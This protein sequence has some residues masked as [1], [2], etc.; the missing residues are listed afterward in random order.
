MCGTAAA[1][2]S[3]S[4]VMR[5]IS[6]PARASAATWP[7]VPCTSAVSVLVIDCTTTG[8][9]PPTVTLPTSTATDWRRSCGPASLILISPEG[10]RLPEGLDGVNA[11]ARHPLMLSGSAAMRADTADLDHRGFRGEAGRPRRRF[12]LGRHLRGRGLAHGA[13]AFAQE[14]HHQLAVGVAV[15]AGDERVAALDPVHQ[16]ILAQEIERTVNR[17]GGRPRAFGRQ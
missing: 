14:E 11:G 17:D 13:A 6:E 9:P 8:A 1:A 2:S 15:H 4:T 5:T 16:A 12:E 3:R 7:A 10:Q